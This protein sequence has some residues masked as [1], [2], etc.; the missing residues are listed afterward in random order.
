MF[1]LFKFLIYKVYDSKDFFIRRKNSFMLSITAFA[2][3][4]I[5]TNHLLLLF[6]IIINHNHKIQLSLFSFPPQSES[7]TKYN[8]NGLLNDTPTEGTLR[9]FFYCLPGI[10]LHASH[11]AKYAPFLS[12]KSLNSLRSSPKLRKDLL[13]LQSRNS[14]SH[15]HI[16]NAILIM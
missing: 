4:F 16:M 9:L 2:I 15:L 1:R 10:N 8:F 5:K 7:G 13:L 12:F 3:L 11:Y 6:K 14:Y